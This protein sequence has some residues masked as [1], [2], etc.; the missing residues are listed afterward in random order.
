MFRRVLRRVLSVTPS[1]SKVGSLQT[2]VE[3]VIRCSNA[4]NYNRSKSESKNGK[5]ETIFPL[6]RIQ[7][8]LAT[9]KK[10]DLYD[11][12]ERHKAT[13]EPV[14]ASE[15]EKEKEK[16]TMSNARHL[17]AQHRRPDTRAAA[18]IEIHAQRREDNAEDRRKKNTIFSRLCTYII[19]YQP[20]PRASAYA[21][22]I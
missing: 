5:R 12:N 14:N 21:R 20:I 16:S 15:M 22:P 2:L 8:D 17:P 4:Y 19:S 3:Y 10:A 11:K 1:H 18:R 9:R 6:H 7:A 13:I